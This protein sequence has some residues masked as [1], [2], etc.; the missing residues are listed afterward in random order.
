LGV[1]SVKILAGQNR[2]FD[3]FYAIHGKDQVHFSTRK[4]TTTNPRYK[5]PILSKGLYKLKYFVVAD[6]FELAEQTF[7]LDFKDIPQSIKFDPL[8]S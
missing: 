8:E 7:I 1:F 6:N 2:E 5:M 4:I 3:A